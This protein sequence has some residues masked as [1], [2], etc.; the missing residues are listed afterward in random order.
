MEKWKQNVN[1]KSYSSDGYNSSLMNVHD[2]PCV[3]KVPYVRVGQKSI[4]FVGIEKRKVL[5]DNG[6]KKNSLL[7][8]NP[9]IFKFIIVDFITKRMNL[10]HE[11]IKHDVRDNNVKSA[12]IYE[13]RVKISTIRF[14]IV[15]C[16]CAIRRL[17]HTVV[18]YFVP[19][20]TGHDTKQHRNA[21]NGRFEICAS[22]KDKKT[23]K[24]RK[25]IFSPNLENVITIEWLN[26]NGF[27]Y[28]LR[29]PSL[30]SRK[31][32]GHEMPKEKVFYSRYSEKYRNLRNSFE[33]LFFF[34][35]CTSMLMNVVTKGKW[36]ELTCQSP[37]HI[38][39]CQR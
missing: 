36:F 38:W 21:S 17:N 15:G 12:E 20:F 34:T 39:Q 10:T 30:S 8:S 33:R 31:K 7:A 28:W 25:L 6:W 35:N 27:W 14:P 5:H 19:I 22:E 13:W 24:Y 11:K 9:I 26:S 37:R 4:L 29:H 18:H 23:A 2:V 16:R 3:L 1:W 32:N